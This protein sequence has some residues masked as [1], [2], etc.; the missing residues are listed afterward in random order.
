MSVSVTETLGSAYT[1]DTATFSWSDTTA[2]KTW[3]TAAPS[4]FEVA[5]SQAFVVAS[6]S[7]RD[8]AKALA[9]ALAVSDALARAFTVS[10]AEAISV[11]ESLRKT[12][13]WR[14]Q[15]VIRISEIDG[16]HVDR[17]VVEAFG[18]SD[19]LVKEISLAI[20]ETVTFVEAYRDHIQWLVEIAESL[21]LV[22]HRASEIHRPLRD[23][24]AISDALTKD[25]G[26]HVSEALSVLDGFARNIVYQRTFLE[27]LGLAESGA[28]D[29]ALAKTEH[30]HAG[31]YVTKGYGLAPHET[32]AVGDLFARSVIFQREL[33]E[34]FSVDEAASKAA[35]KSVTE[36]L[37][38]LEELVQN[39]DGVLSDLEIRSD[40][41]A[42]HGFASAMSRAAPPGFAAFERLVGGDYEF[43]KALIRYVMSTKTADRPE[44]THLR[45]V[46]DMPDV[47]DSGAKTLVAGDNVIPF[48]RT[49]H[50]VP[51]V[52][53]TL[54]GGSVFAIPRITAISETDFTMH[55]EATDGSKVAGDIIWNAKGY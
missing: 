38:F 50:I 10:K 9:E 36:T 2:S 6:M 5:A 51:E 22:D 33:A 12:A 48:N 8:G 20:A 11:A 45:T 27:L 3:D 29:T 46:V 7:R 41:I 19:D 49:F 31:D 44:L 23:S 55:L 30:F 28:R 52:T 13:H 16:R 14:L 42:S 32:V 15:E 43:K 34:G 17:P 37:E 25:A 54:K 53:A 39:P 21:R 1:W 24:F 40:A 18:M 4:I 47:I 26:K 35:G